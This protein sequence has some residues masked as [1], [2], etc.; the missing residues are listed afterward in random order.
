M[1]DIKNKALNEAITMQNDVMV[2]CFERYFDILTARGYKNISFEEYRT[3]ELPSNKGYF[4]QYMASAKIAYSMSDAFKIINKEDKAYVFNPLKEFLSVPA[5]IDIIH[6][7]G[8]IAIWAHPTIHRLSPTDLAQTVVK[9]KTMGI[10]G[11]EVYS[12]GI[13]HNE[14]ENILDLAY[15]HRLLISGGSDFHGKLNEELGVVQQGKN[16][17]YSVLTELI[18]HHQLR[19]SIK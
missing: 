9:F 19:Y 18:A 2:K 17:P 5:A 6:N 7:A 15:K 4:R 11:I 3:Q 13:M 16:M 12:P 10:D 8:G 1:I 14:Y